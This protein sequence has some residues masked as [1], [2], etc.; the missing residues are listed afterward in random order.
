MSGS[1]LAT[2]LMVAL[3]PTAGVAAGRESPTSRVTKPIAVLV[4]DE[5]YSAN[6]AEAAAQVIEGTNESRRGEGRGEV[7]AN[8]V[9][10]AAARAFAAYL[11][12][13]D[14]YGHDAD[15]LRPFERAAQQ[16]Y[17]SCVLSENLA[18]QYLSTG[19]RTEDL[20]MSL[21]EGWLDSPG[22]RANLLDPDVTEIGVAIARSRQTGR[23]YAVQMFGRPRDLQF[24]FVLRNESGTGVQYQLDQESA[25]LPSGTTVTHQRCRPAQLTFHWG[26]QAPAHVAVSNGR[27]YVVKRTPDGGFALQER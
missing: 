27:L 24:A 19:F 14:T 12:D 6:V 18:Y 26:R 22:H 17:E 2:L 1:I 9:L 15:G 20:A 8:P 23:Y 7:T 3:L 21:V 11:A 5:K 16:G 13:T 10:M 4:M 25:P